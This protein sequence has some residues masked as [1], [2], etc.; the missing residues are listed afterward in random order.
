MNIRKTLQ[1]LLGAVLV[2]M[3]L[4][5]LASMRPVLNAIISTLVKLVNTARLQ[6]GPLDYV[7]IDLPEEMPPFPEPTNPIQQRLL[8][9]PPLSQ[10]ELE[11][12][13]RR[14]A[15]DPRVTGVILRLMG[16]QMS[17]ADLQNIRGSMARLRSKGKRVIC[18]ARGY[19]TAM[20]YLASAADEIILQPG[21]ELMTV[22]LARNITFMKEALGAVGLQV[23]SIAISPYKSAADTLTEQTPT[24]EVDAQLNWLL[25]DNYEQI[26]HGIAEGRGISPEAARA[27]ID[28]APYTDRQALEA[29]YVDALSNEEDFPTR[30]ESEHI[31]VRQ[32]A[33][34]ILPLRIP[35]RPEKYIGVL[36]LEGVIVDGESQRPP[37]DVPVPLMGG[38]RLGSE[39]VVR[40]VRHLMKQD[41]IAAVVLHI[42][43]RGGSATASEAMAAALAELATTRPVIAYMGD[44]AASGGYY[45]ATPAHWIIAQPGTITGSIGVIMAKV[46]ASDMLKKL[47]FNAVDYVRGANAQIFSPRAPFSDEQRARV[48]ESIERIYEQFVGRVARARGM[49][50]EG[51]DEVGGGR[52]WTGAQAY[53]HGLVDELGDLDCALRKAR[54]LA[55]LPEKTPAFLIRG[56]AKPI[57]PQVAEQF[58]PAAGLHYARRNVQTL[59]SGRALYWMPWQMD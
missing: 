59:L 39:T 20:Y 31:R 44:V 11:Q 56:K 13:F 50:P 54:E 22:G 19:D 6:Q 42:N 23:D 27:F 16:L 21:G 7:M 30:Y 51:V 43:S 52:V 25:D 2:L 9:E 34:N 57:A 53:G 3:P 15:D 5:R 28:N 46:I 38:A 35:L 48:R 14:V 32:Q 24:P 17:L 36:S 26:I 1:Y 41:D 47:N 58:N 29:G 18:Y 10:V 12:L 40:Q 33:E 8:G 4:W 49:S 45:I 37:R 55:G